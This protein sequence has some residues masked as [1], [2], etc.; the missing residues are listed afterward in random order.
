MHI[1]CE[2]NEKN[3]VQSYDANTVII[4]TKAYSQSI[5]VTKDN[6]VLLH[7]ANIVQDINFSWL[8]HIEPHAKKQI[9]I[10]IIGQNKLN[11]FLTPEQYASF[12]T[13]NI[14][15]EHMQFGAACR[16]FNL[17]LSEKRKIGMVLLF[18]S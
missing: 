8:Q 5:L 4:A 12:I 10:L 6:I 17:L 16:T 3:S 13:N 7:D 2:P 9:S 11:Q 18:G 14:G 1:Q 15:V